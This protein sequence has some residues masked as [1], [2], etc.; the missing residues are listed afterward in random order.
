MPV[1]LPLPGRRHAGEHGD[2]A[3]RAH[4]HLGPVGAVEEQRA[5]HRAALRD[6]LLPD[7]EADVATLGS[8]LLLDEGEA[9][10]VD[11]VEHRAERLRVVAAVDHRA[12]D[13]GERELLGRDEVLEA[14]LGAVAPG[15]LGDVIHDPVHQEGRRVLAVT[16]VGVPRALV[17]HDRA[18][19]R[20]R[21]RDLVD[22]R[23]AVPGDEGHAP[24][25]ERGGGADVGDDRQADP[26][27]RAVVLVRGLVVEPRVTGVA[28]PSGSSRCAPRS[29]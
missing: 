14:D 2:L 17:R 20:L 15:L 27:D 21:V 18:K 3:R 19:V 26:G 29:T 9:L 10:V 23:Q 24:A 16:A 13:L 25:A 11:H 28:R 4:P 7:A 1:S 8:R 5:G 12:R 22:A 6:Q